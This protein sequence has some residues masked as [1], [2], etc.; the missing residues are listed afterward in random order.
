MPKP[1]LGLIELLH[2]FQ[3]SGKAGTGTLQ[4]RSVTASQLAQDSPAK[5]HEQTGLFLFYGTFYSRHRQIPFSTL[6]L[7]VSGE[8]SGNYF[9]L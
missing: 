8:Q 4:T 7:A 1:F 5:Q 3:P 2:L 6:S 9:L